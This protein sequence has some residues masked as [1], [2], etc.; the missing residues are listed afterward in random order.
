MVFMIALVAFPLVFSLVVAMKDYTLKGGLDVL[1][2]PTVG[3]ENFSKVLAD[4]AFRDAIIVTAKMGAAC[5]VIQFVLGFLIALVV[6]ELSRDRPDR[7]YTT[8]I[9]IPLMIAPIA[10]ALIWRTLL[11]PQ[12]GYFNNVITA[13]KGTPIAFLSDPLLAQISVVVVD[14][15]QWTP[16]VFLILLAGLKSIP[17]ELREAAR[18]D[19][20]SYMY[21]FR[22]VILPMMTWPILLVVLIRGVDIVRMFDYVYGLT[23]GGPGSA[24][25]TVSFY[26]YL[27]GFKNFDL[28]RGAAASWLIFLVVYGFALIVLRNRRAME[29]WQ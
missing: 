10:A 2:M 22:K 7:V 26:A 16:F 8:M 24:T 12:Y 25:T 18:S 9:L 3:L 11:N 19:G 1:A 29:A 28:A 21:M 5:L 14:T 13:F 17:E 15:W 27:T 20:A 6:D 23:F 4:P